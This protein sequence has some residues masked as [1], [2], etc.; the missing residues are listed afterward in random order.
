MIVAHLAKKFSRPYGTQSLHY[1]VHN[2][3]LN[4]LILRDTKHHYHVQKIHLNPLTLLR[5]TKLHYHVHK[6]HLNPFIH[7]D[8]SCINI[9]VYT[10]H[11][12]DKPV[13]TAVQPTQLSTTKPHSGMSTITIV[14]STQHHTFKVHYT[15][16]T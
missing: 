5:D 11:R 14:L 6:S 10:V 8:H 1:H 2:S 16:L 4:P 15:A 3:H 7:T 9:S 13:V 12:S